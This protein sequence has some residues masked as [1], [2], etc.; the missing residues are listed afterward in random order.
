M[1]QTY[2]I[3]VLP[4]DGI[5]P[6]VV[7]EAVKVLETVADGCGFSIHTE[8]AD[9]GGVALDKYDDPLPKA[10]LELCQ[11]SDA[12]L[13]GAIGD[14]KWDTMPADKRPERGLLGLREGL[15]LFANLRPAKI[16]PSLADASSLRRDV[17]E[18]IDISLRR[19]P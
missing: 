16:F 18:D 15:G 7:K 8:Y 19:K 2:K 11:T 3:T 17:V 9:V 6:E 12:V 5:G 4:G 14:P 13:L 1:K 10:T